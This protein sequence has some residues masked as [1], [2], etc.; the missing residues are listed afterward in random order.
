MPKKGDRAQTFVTRRVGWGQGHEED[1]DEDYG[2]G[3]KYT[4]QGDKRAQAPRPGKQGYLPPSNSGG[5]HVSQAPSN[6]QVQYPGGP[7]ATGAHPNQHSNSGPISYPST[8]GSPPSAHHGQSTRQLNSTGRY[9]SQD[10]YYGSPP[11]G[12]PS[13]PYQPNQPMGQQSYP[14]QDLRR[15]GPEDRTWTEPAYHQGG[16]QSPPPQV[17]PPN[18]FPFTQIPPSLNPTNSFPYAS[19]PEPYCQ[20]CRFQYYWNT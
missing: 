5:P 7:P 6:S 15:L 14:F 18:P 4:A 17:N 13:T 1:S 16:Y 8:S 11:P 9:S 20:R 2:R 19:N 10:R 12:P 3:G